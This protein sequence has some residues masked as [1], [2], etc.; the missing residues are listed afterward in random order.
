M[1][2]VRRSISEQR[3]FSKTD[4]PPHLLQHELIDVLPGAPLSSIFELSPI[5]PQDDEASTASMAQALFEAG[6]Y[7][8]RG[9]GF[10]Y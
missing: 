2:L 5:V 10:S 9:P 4:R 6:F 8:A 7:W 3:T 1:G